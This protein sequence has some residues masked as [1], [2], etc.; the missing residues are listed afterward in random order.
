MQKKSG[1]LEEAFRLFLI[2]R[3]LPLII[4]LLKDVLVTFSSYGQSSESDEKGVKEHHQKMFKSFEDK[5]I[6]P[7]ETL[8]AK[9]SQYQEFIEHVLD[10]DQLP[11]LEVNCIHDE[12]LKEL[13]EERQTLEEEA[14]ILLKQAQKSWASFATISLDTNPSNKSYSK[15]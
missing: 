14:Q 1:G 9:F 2:G 5:F 15:E 6:L 10:L 12:E 11:A 7:L 3:S 8:E 4:A 13:S